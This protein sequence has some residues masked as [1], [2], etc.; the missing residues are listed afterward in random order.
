MSNEDRNSMNE[1]FR[2]ADNLDEA[3]QRELDEA[4][5]GMSIEDIV[6][7]EEQAVKAARPAAGAP[8]G[9]ASG[10]RR[11][12]VITR[13][14]ED[15]Y[16]D[17]G[18]KSQGVITVSQFGPDEPLPEA[19]QF[20]DVVIEGFDS[21]N[22]ML[23][24]SR[25]GAVMQ[26][27]W[28]TLA[29]GQTVEGRVTG[30]NKGGLELSI[31]NIRA[32][33]PISQVEL[34]HVEDLT[35]YLNTKMRC[36]VTEVNREEKNVIVSRRAILEFEAQEQREKTWES[37]IEGQTV[38]GVVKNLMPYGAFVDIGGIDG[39]LHVRD[40][41]HSR[42][43]DPATVVQAGQVLEVKIL[44]IDR[45]AR[46]ISLGLKQAMPDPWAGAADKWP[47]N[48]MVSGRVT[49][50]ADFGAFVELEPG[51]E[52]LIPIGEMTFAKR[53]NH[54]SEIVKVG[55]VVTVRVMSVDLERK[56]ISLSIKRAGDDPWMGASARWPD[57]SIVDGIVKRTT[58]FGAF[59]E[60]TAGVE[61]LV[62]ISELSDQRVRTAA[63]AVQVGQTV[64]CK[65]LT[66]EEDR[67]RI[68]LSIK[69]A[70]MMGAFATSMTTTS[71]PDPE[72]PQ[73]KRKKPLKGG[74]E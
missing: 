19:G 20:V 36:N 45:E 8:A 34:F 69:Q 22:G 35:P 59:V 47:V 33:M 27:A 43:E 61:G 3:L 57:G 5:G 50:L 14:G 41:S 24:L 65:V 74:L 1:K 38:R 21:E 73:P 67:R 58:E 18:G 51:V 23:V 28:E 66:V 31:N 15:I 64:K 37:L 6:S 10:V 25:E 52:G 30:L 29:E 71:E 11:G 62:H 17:M 9:A 48:L 16:V 60:L 4:L 49:R 72:K 12:T 55:D 56:R 2:P 7:A 42:V 40:M 70:A 63:D 68:S 53:I 44:K 39:L 13:Q 26:A 46:R 54:P 32:F